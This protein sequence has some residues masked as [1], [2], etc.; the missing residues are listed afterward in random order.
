MLA[1]LVT[2]ACYLVAAGPLVALGRVGPLWGGLLVVPLLLLG[3]LTY[4]ASWPNLGKLKLPVAIYILVLV[5]MTLVALWAWLSAPRA[6][7]RLLLGLGS[8]LFFVSDISVA[9]ERFIKPSFRNQLWGPPCYF[10][11][12][13]LLAFSIGRIGLEATGGG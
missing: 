3:G 12:Q 7:G 6:P 5:A 11:A 10:S 9:R 13:F 4:W 8:V 1:F 2:H